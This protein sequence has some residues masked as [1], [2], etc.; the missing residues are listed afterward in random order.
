MSDNH[1]TTREKKP[2]ARAF[3]PSSPVSRAPLCRGVD[4]RRSSIPGA[5]RG[6]W[7]AGCLPHP[8]WAEGLV[9][10][11]GTQDG[12]AK[13]GAA[14]EGLAV[15]L[16]IGM[17]ASEARAQPPFGG[18]P[19]MMGGA[20]DGWAADGRAAPMRPRWGCRRWAGSRWA[21]RRWAG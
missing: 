13:H 5:R 7:V 18:P 17:A 2:G 19:P 10:P 1:P 12:I 14:D 6:T 20:A 9:D 4:R 15:L 16:V 11:G 8:A 21:G 3:R